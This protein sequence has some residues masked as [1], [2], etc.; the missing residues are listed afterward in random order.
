MSETDSKRVTKY[1]LYVINDDGEIRDIVSKIQEY[2]KLLE[3]EKY[4][5]STIRVF[6]K[7][8]QT[9]F[10][11]TDKNLVMITDNLASKL[12]NNSDSPYYGNIEKYAFN[13]SDSIVDGPKKLYGY[14]HYN[15]DSAGCSL[16]ADVALKAIF[17][18]MYNF[19]NM[20]LL[21]IDDYRIY[22]KDYDKEEN[23]FSGTFNI[24]FKEN[25]DF[26]L[27]A[28]IRSYM[29]NMFIFNNPYYN[30]SSPRFIVRFWN[31]YTKKDNENKDKVTDFTDKQSK[32][33][34][35]DDN[36]GFKKV[37]PRGYKGM[38]KPYNANYKKRNANVVEAVAE[39]PAI[40][41]ISK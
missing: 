40:E 18:F 20:K 37:T 39:D 11:S 26:E 17:N 10:T 35:K 5:Y 3:L 6:Y 21:T 29:N 31:P 38:R 30:R 13:K 9:G 34:K 14:F 2:V 12:I 1:P 28:I 15:H 19:I 4:Y 32:P 7:K 16:T 36:K 8:N 24:N 41:E 27:I 25:V 33:L 23:Y 22:L